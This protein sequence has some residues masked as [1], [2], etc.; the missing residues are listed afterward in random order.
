[1]PI[2]WECGTDTAY[3]Q[4]DYSSD[5]SPGLRFS[6]T[7]HSCSMG[8]QVNAEGDIAIIH[9]VGPLEVKERV[10]VDTGTYFGAIWAN[11][12]YPT[13][14]T[15]C[16]DDCQVHEK[17]CVCNDVNVQTSAVFIDLPTLQDLDS[18]Q[19]GATN[20]S[21]FDENTYYLCSAPQC[22]LQEYKVHF[23]SN[24]VNDFDIPGAFDAD[25]IFE[26]TLYDGTTQFLSNAESTVQIGSGL[27]SFR[28]P[29]MF[30]SPIDPVQR[31][32]LYETDAILQHHAKHPNTAPFIATKMI[33]F[34]ITS[35]PS[36]RYVQAAANAFSTGS[37]AAD[38]HSFGTGKYGVSKS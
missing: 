16:G 30:N 9:S 17:T 37:Y 20:P 38:G 13:V 21:L 28:N 29:P 2:A 12:Q 5:S 18:L 36:P 8:V 6:W 25:T 10:A 4:G 19:I 27:Y 32:G 14:E 1:M 31:D 26:M 35:N 24:V 11:N 7:S 23:R 34:L 3:Y 33:N 22:S 15:N